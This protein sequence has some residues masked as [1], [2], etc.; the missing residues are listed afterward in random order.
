MKQ[1]KIAAV[2][3]FLSI[4]LHSNEVTLK[5]ET[6]ISNIEANIKANVLQMLR[7]PKEDKNPASVIPA[8]GYWSIIHGQ[9]NWDN[10]KAKCAALGMRLPTGTEIS[11]LNDAKL[12]D[13]ESYWTSEDFNGDEP[14]E[15][16]RPDDYVSPPNLI[17]DYAWGLSRFEEFSA[18]SAYKKEQKLNVRCI[19]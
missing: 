7:K 8:K 15:E 10:A 2:L 16:D 9:M 17:K 6:V 4:T 19:R 11:N 14:S 12:K 1:I 5:N 18:R 13:G 3:S